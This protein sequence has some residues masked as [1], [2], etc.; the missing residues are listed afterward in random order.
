MI[1][2][3]RNLVKSDVKCPEVVS[4][5]VENISLLCKNSFNK[6]VGIELIYMKGFIPLMPTLITHSNDQL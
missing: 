3:V 1:S 2:I 5:L 6:Q 4:D